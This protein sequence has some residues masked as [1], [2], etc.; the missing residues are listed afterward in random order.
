MNKDKFLDAVKLGAK[1]L[2]VCLIAP[3]VGYG[4]FALNEEYN[5]IVSSYPLLEYWV[6]LIPKGITYLNGIVTGL[7]VGGIMTG[8]ILEDIDIN[9]KRKLLSNPKPRLHHPY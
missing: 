7:Y 4:M 6:P 9:K 8:F 1:F 2:S 5:S 3:S